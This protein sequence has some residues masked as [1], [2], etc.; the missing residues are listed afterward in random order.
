MNNS[1]KVIILGDPGVGKDELL[2]K[3]ATQKFDEEYVSTPFNLRSV[4][5]LKE[6]IELKEYN[7]TLDLEFWDIVGHPLH[8][9]FF[10]GA[11]GILLVFDITSSNTFENI[12]NWY[13]FAAKCGLSGIP[14]ILVG[15]NAH[16]GNG[17]KISIQLAEHLCEQLNIYH[18]YETSPLTGYNVKEVFEK[19]AELIYSIKRL[20]I[21]AK[22]K[23][24]IVKNYREEAIEP[25]KTPNFEV[26]HPYWLDAL[27][28]LGTF[29]AGFHSYPSYIKIRRL[30]KTKKKPLTEEE[31]RDRKERAN[32]Y[33]EN[34][35]RNIEKWEKRVK[36]IEAMK[37]SEE[38]KK[39]KPFTIIPSMGK[40]KTKKER[41][42]KLSM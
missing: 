25:Y 42:Y 3:L 38:I 37:K 5:I 29:T 18:Y 22:S 17:R 8:R 40:S 31:K 1:Y 35:R 27:D 13:D 41:K 24:L 33:F 32:L 10:N 7:V 26:I 36:L 4:S 30:K 14:K 12:K 9:P 19:I 16:L 23:E 21:P 15:N 2:T 6:S 11:D 28:N 39:E 34:E 20:K